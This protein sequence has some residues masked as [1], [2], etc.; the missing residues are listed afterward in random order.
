MKD[1]KVIEEYKSLRDQIKIEYFSL[2]LS[3][4]DGDNF[5]PIPK[6]AMHTNGGGQG[7]KITHLP[8]GICALCRDSRSTVVNKDYALIMLINKIIE[9][10]KEK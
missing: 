2:D 9:K 7:V 10:E 5:Y 1:K 4:V 8:T 6:G 3:Y